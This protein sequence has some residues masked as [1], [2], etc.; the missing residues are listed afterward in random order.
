MYNNLVFTFSKIQPVDETGAGDAFGS[1][2]IVG[3]IKGS[4]LT[5]SFNLAMANGASVVKFLGAKKGLLRN[6]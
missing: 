3:L 5:G 2:F 6:S 4:S 1:G